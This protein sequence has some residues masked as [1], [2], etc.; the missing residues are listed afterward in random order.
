M[1]GS[2]FLPLATLFPPNIAVALAQ[3]MK[4]G[5]GVTESAEMRQEFVVTAIRGKQQILI[6]NTYNPCGNFPVAQ[7]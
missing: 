5:F 3:T 2:L 6:R 1:F 7:L 4:G